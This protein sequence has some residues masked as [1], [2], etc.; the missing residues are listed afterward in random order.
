MAEYQHL[1]I[2]LTV[3]FMVVNEQLD[4]IVIIMAVNE[5]LDFSWKH[6]ILKLIRPQ[7]RI[8]RYFM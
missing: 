6:E 8:L 3:I 2:L 7:G 1:A 4:H 5:H